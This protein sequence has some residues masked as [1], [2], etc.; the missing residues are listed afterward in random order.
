[1]N[2]KRLEEEYIMS[3]KMQSKTEN[4][5]LE[6]QGQLPRPEGLDLSVMTRAIVD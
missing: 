2:R 1:M 3:L 4:C 6:L 5:S